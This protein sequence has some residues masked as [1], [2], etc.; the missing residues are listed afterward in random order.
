[1][2]ARRFSRSGAMAF[3]VTGFAVS[4]ALGACAH[5]T[6]PPPAPL[7]PTAAHLAGHLSPL[8]Q[9]HLA[10]VRGIHEGPGV[11]QRARE[12]GILANSVEWWV[13]GP[14]EVLPFA[15][16]WRGIAGIAEFERRLDATMRYDRVELRRYLVSGD[17]VA[18]LFLGAGVAK[19]TSRRFESEI[20]RLY[21]FR[22][23]KVV[24]VRNYYDTAAYVAAVRGH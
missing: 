24:R 9:Q 14:A 16:T 22:G 13:A 12:S 20:V 6:E 2:R 17:D 18:A 19:A 21:T 11:I 1:M 4:A 5:R 8:E 10:V 3:A 7:P 15:G 23:G